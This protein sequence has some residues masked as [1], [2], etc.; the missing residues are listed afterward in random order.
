MVPPAVQSRER[1]LTAA[2]EIFAAKGLHGARVDEIASK[3]KVNKGMLYHYFHS[4]EDLYTA[5][6]KANFEKILAAT[7][8]AAK[9]KGDPQEQLV[10]AIKSYFYFLA[11]NP[12]FARLISWEALE[13]GTYARKVLSPIWEEGLPQI[14][15]I[16]E[17]GKAKGIF[18]PDLDIRQM[19]TSIS[20]LCIS[21]FTQKDILAILWEDDPVRPENLER[22][23]QHILEL[24]LRNVLL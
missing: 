18:R 1:I 12:R 16:L 17:E 3:A 8:Q 15:K 4:K 21:Y 19:L 24:V 5:V 11:E 7:S 2:E 6:L 9:G 14:K 20:S 23:L 10:E 13:G 22:R